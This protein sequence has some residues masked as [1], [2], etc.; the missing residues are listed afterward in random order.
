PAV[1][2]TIVGGA[3]DV[4]FKVS[5]EA[6]GISLSKMDQL[7]RHTYDQPIAASRRTFSPQ[8]SLLGSPFNLPVA[9]LIAR[10]FGGDLSLVSMEGHGTDTYLHLPRRKSYMESL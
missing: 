5:D 10:H 1:R 7:W 9:R 8:L 4:A 6:G 3:E 2:L